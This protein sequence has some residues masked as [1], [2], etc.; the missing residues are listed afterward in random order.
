VGLRPFACWDCGFESCRGDGCLSL[1]R[2]L[3][4]RVEISVTGESLV[5]RSPTE[6]GVSECDLETST[7]SMPRS[8]LGCRAT[9]KIY[10]MLTWN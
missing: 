3:Y 8:E 10:N 6:R 1:V 4:C 2:V 7:I 9:K 5:Q